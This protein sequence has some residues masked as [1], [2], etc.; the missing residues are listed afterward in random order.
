MAY[1]NHESYADAVAAGNVFL[2]LPREIRQII[3]DWVVTMQLKSCEHSHIIEA[4]DVLS[5][6][7][8]TWLPPMC[9]VND[10]FFFDALPVVF[11]RS[12]FIMRSQYE[13]FNLLFFLR[14]TETFVHVRS[15]SFYASDAFLISSA[16][17]ELI[18]KCTNLRAVGMYFEWENMRLAPVTTGTCLDKEWFF[19]AYSIDQLLKLKSIR[20]I[21]LF[22]CRLEYV[23][24][25]K[26]VVSWSLK[27]QRN[28]VDISVQEVRRD[29]D[30]PSYGYLGDGD[31]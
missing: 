20:R 23:R 7:Q 8:C 17:A 24:P 4:R 9:L 12:N 25:L 19:E 30:L 27:Q 18:K 13:A 10:A 5:E 15:L 6:Q 11:R 1:L 14:T 21:T 28:Q 2:W 22:A 31:E 26:E 29:S 3:F 16:G